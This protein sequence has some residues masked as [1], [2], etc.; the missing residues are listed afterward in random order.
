MWALISIIAIFGY[1]GSFAILEYLE[2]KLTLFCDLMLQVGW[3]IVG[4]TMLF[5]RRK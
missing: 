5:W 1:I 4:S 2:F 3:L